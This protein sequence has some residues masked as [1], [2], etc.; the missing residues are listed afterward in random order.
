M[1]MKIINS[2][3]IFYNFFRKNHLKD[4]FKDFF[5]I[6]SYM[7]KAIVNCSESEN[8]ENYSSLEEYFLDCCR[9]GLKFIQFL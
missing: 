2:L 9:F 1:I 3:I 4:K 8:E 6:L 7:E 5:I